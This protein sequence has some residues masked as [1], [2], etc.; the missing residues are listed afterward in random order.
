MSLPTLFEYYASSQ[1]TSGLVPKADGF[2]L[3][4]K[5]ITLC[6]GSLHYFRVPQEYWRDRLRKF[7]AAGLNAIETYVPWNLHEPVRDSYDFG[8]GNNDYSDLLDIVKFIQTAQEEDLF[9][10]VRP[11][12]YICAE[13]DFGG[14]PSWLLNEDG[15]KLR[16]S[17]P[18]FM[19]RVTNYFSKLLPLFT[20]LQFTKGGSIIAF[21]VENE[22]GSVESDGTVPDIE[23]LKAVK[24][25]YEDHGLVELFFTADTPTLH[26]DAGSLPGVLQTA[27]CKIYPD[28]EL[29]LLKELQPDKPLMVIEYWTGWFDHWLEPYHSIEPVDAYADRL[30]KILNFPSSVNFYM[31]H[32]GTSFGFMNGANV[33]THYQP[34]VTSYDY[35]APISESGD[36]TEKYYKTKEILAKFQTVKTKLPEPPAKTPKY[37]YSSIKAI[38]HLDFEDLLAQVGAEFKVKLPNVTNMENLPIKNGNGQSYGY[39]NY[40]KKVSL[41]TKSTLKISGY[42]TDTAMVLVD[43]ELKSKPLESVEDINGFGYWMQKDAEL[44][45]NSDKGGSQTLDIIVENWGRVN[46][47]VLSNFDQRKGLWQG[48]VY[49]DGNELKDW[50]IY[51]LE[52]TSKWV[53]SLENWKQGPATNKVGPTVSKFVLRLTEVYDTFIDLRSWSKGIIFVNGFNLGRYCHLGPTGTQYLPAP[54]LTKGENEILVFDHFQSNSELSFLDYPILGEAKACE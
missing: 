44:T 30:E 35:D 11:G 1:V 37:A 2:Y 17:E 43:G 36:Y 4:G 18:K 14:L 10:I 13:W 6:S 51:A 52:F 49:L 27:T 15:I 46:F 25:L 7:R 19:K 26:K 33:F 28:A 40:R 9:V 45:I 29:Y 53:K 54:L 34:D 39:I 16:T 23:Y 42:V 24:K 41:N 21:Q 38:A 31:F 22:Y 5:K 50:E 12:P 8:D 3:N 47:G 32:G 48:P 20:D